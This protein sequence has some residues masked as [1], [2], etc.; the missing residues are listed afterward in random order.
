[1]QA[2]AGKYFDSIVFQCVIGVRTGL[3][4]NEKAKTIR[5]E[6]A[7]FQRLIRVDVPEKKIIEKCIF[8]VY[9]RHFFYVICLC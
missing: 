7:K 4:G 5:D 6:K 9:R 3:K 1:M 2:R 8:S